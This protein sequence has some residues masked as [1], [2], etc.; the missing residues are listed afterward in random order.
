M[1]KL[2]VK[3]LKW[4]TLKVRGSV[5]HFCQKKKNWNV[6]I[7]GLVA[8][9][10][11]LSIF[12]GGLKLKSIHYNYQIIQK[13]LKHVLVLKKRICLQGYNQ[14]L[15]KKKTETQGYLRQASH[16]LDFAC[17]RP[18][19]TTVTLMYLVS[20]YLRNCCR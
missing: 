15:L 11:T 9:I 6:V 20:N 17:H 4:K 13:K 7:K 16:S 10:A 12:N 3:G 5:L 8:Q 19:T 14:S 18:P 2:K 1:T